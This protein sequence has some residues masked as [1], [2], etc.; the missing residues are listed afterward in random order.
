VKVQLAAVYASERA[1]NIFV[2]KGGTLRIDQAL[3]FGIH[4]RTL[5]VFHD[6]ARLQRSFYRLA[7]SAPSPLLRENSVTFQYQCFY[8]LR[9]L[10]ARLVQFVIVR[11]Y[12]RGMIFCFCTD[13]TLDPLE[14]IMLYGYRLRSEFGFGQAV[15]VFGADSLPESKVILQL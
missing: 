13:L 1:L 9:R 12:Y 5:Y 8:L 4:P 7:N 3:E 11:H 2:G 10:T 14:I 15:H 6:D